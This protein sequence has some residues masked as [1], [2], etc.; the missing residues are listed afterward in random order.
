MNTSF[1][2]QT[3]TPDSSS[4]LF[5]GPQEF[6]ECHFSHLDLTGVKLTLSRFIECTFT[7]CNLSNADVKNCTFRHCHFSDCKLLGIDWSSTSTLALYEFKNC[8]LDYGI[9]QS[10]NLK[11]GIFLNCSLKEADF[12]SAHLNDTDLSGSKLSGANF[13]RADLSSCDLRG[14]TEYSI[15]PTFTNVTKARFS[16]PEVL[17]LLRPF[18]IIID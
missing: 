4:Q 14:A 9:F 16:M 10:M 8:I 1:E 5:N 17:S 12:Q 18:G 2:N 3:F 13:N 11:K 15:E 6:S 7:D